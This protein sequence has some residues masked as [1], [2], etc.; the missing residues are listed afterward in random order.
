MIIKPKTKRI[1][2]QALKED[3]GAG[4]ITTR[5]VIPK[6]QQ[7]KFIVLPNEHCIVCGIALTEAC[8][9]IIDKDVHFRP[10]VSDGA[11]VSKGKIVAHI[12]GRCYGVLIAERAALNFLGWLSGISTLTNKFVNAVKNYKAQIMDTRK[13][14][15]TL[16]YLQKYA[17]K[18]GGGKNHRMGL[19]DQILIKDNHLSVVSKYKKKISV[20]VAIEKARKYG[21]KDK[22]IEIEVKNLGEF[23]EVLSLNPDIIMLDNMK[24]NDVKEAVQL[25]DAYRIKKGDIGFK[26]LL[27]VSGNVNLDNVTEIAQTGVDRI[28]IGALT[29]SAP[30]IDF[31]LKAE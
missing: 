14:I 15:P 3:I 12:E 23:K 1:I 2:E 24:I 21:P 6:T 29:H 16:R 17:V 28:S 30:A 22:K 26:T 8:F 19:Y 10:M 31:S 7:G 11:Y 9:T 27:E 25:R 13:T 4:D 20:T 5:S 18:I